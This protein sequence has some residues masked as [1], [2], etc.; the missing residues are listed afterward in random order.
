M[1]QTAFEQKMRDI[2][3]YAVALILAQHDNDLPVMLLCAN[4]LTNAAMSVESMIDRL[5]RHT[6][7]QQASLY[8]RLQH[9]PL[10]R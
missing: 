4:E 2:Q 1:T 3:K 7:A 10:P 8:E 6:L 9:D 5:H